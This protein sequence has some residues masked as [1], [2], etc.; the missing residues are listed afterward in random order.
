MLH[1]E[2]IITSEEVILEE[3]IGILKVMEIGLNTHLITLIMKILK[4]KY[5]VEIIT[6]LQS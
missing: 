3:T 2:I 4:E 1:L 5:Q 6:M